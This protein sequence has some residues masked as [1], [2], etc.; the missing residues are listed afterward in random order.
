MMGLEP[1]N[2][3][4]NNFQGCRNFHFCHMFLDQTGIEPVTLICKTNIFPIKLQAFFYKYK[5]H[6]GFEPLSR[7]LEVEYFTIKLAS[8]IFYMSVSR[9]EL[10]LTQLFRLPLYH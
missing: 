1:I 7:R 9:I 6:K 4:G 2:L 10:L 8:Y 5:S 3:K